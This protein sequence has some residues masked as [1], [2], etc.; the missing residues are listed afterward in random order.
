MSTKV[1]EQTG[2]RWKG[3]GCLGLL[4]VLAGFGMMFGFFGEGMIAYGIITFAV[5]VLFYLL[6][7]VGSWWYHE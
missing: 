4:G 7:K 6:G 3:Y 1:I 2:K 5:G